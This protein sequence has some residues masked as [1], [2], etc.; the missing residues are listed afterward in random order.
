MDEILHQL[1]GLLLGA[2]PTAILFIVLVLAY[3]FL[4]FKPLLA[5]LAERRARTEG[6]IEKANAAIAAADAKSQEYEAR[7]RAARTEIFRR[8]EQRMQHWNAER[9][10][11]LESARQSAHE[12]ALTARA[13]IEAQAGAARTQ[14]ESSID[15][16]AAQIL[17]AILPANT[18]NAAQGESPR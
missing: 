17:K 5:T 6:A 12:R 9:E 10:R 14:I 15:Q 3:R 18:G 8:R 4:L 13:A 11:A 2:L 16:L 1:V 7:L